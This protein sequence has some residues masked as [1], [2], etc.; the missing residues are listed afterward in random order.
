[1]QDLKDIY[2]LNHEN[3][4]AWH[5]FLVFRPRG[6]LAHQRKSSKIDIY[7]QCQDRHLGKNTYTAIVQLEVDR[8]LS[9]SKNNSLPAWT[10]KNRVQQLV[11]CTLYTNGV[12]QAGC[13][14][15]SIAVFHWKAYSK[16]LLHILD[17]RD[18]VCPSAM[19]LGHHEVST[20]ICRLGLLQRTGVSGTMNIF[21]L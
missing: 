2:L 13:I 19:D 1:M 11:P 9:K 15:F 21:N 3:P 7:E 8:H 17:G 6:R 4:R 16:C 12:F 10:P 20:Q 5:T 14:Q 18:L